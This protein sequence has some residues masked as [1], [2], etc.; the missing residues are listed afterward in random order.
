VEL[1]EELFHYESKMIASFLDM[2][3]GEEGEKKYGGCLA[4]KAM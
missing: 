4:M 3:E 1:S 2:I